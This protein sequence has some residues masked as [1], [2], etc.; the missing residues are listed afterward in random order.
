MIKG[1][2]KTC[3]VGKSISVILIMV[4]VFGMP[5]KSQTPQ[6]AFLWQKDDSF[7]KSGITVIPDSI[8]AEKNATIVNIL[9]GQISGVKASSAD[10]APGAAFDILIRGINSVRG[11]N[12]PLFIV[13]GIML[14]S[15]NMDVIN[16]WRVLD[17][18]D[19]Q[20]GQ[21]LLWGLNSDNIAQIDV[22]KD[23]SATALYGSK[24]AN[25]VV[26]IK[27]KNGN[28]KNMELKWISNIG[29]SSLPKR[30]DLLSADQYTTYRNKLSSPFNSTGLQSADWQNEAFRNAISNNHNLS[31]SGTVRSTSYNLSLFYGDEQG[32]VKG[33]FAKNFGFKVNL[34]Q[35]I[36]DKLL[37]GTRILFSNSQV[38]MTQSN[39]YL[40][41]GGLINQ[42]SAA[43][44]EGLSENAGSWLNGYYDGANS[45]RMLPNMY[46][47]MQFSRS[48]S[49]IMNGGADYVKKTRLRW[50]GTEIDRGIV[51]NARA[52][53]SDLSALQYN[54][55]ATLTFNRFINN[56]HQFHFDLTGGYFGNENIA[57]STQSSDFFSYTLRAKG[58]NLGA[59]MMG[60]IYTK[61]IS[62]TAFATVNALY[63]Y[64][65]IYQIK[66][67]LRSDYL[68]DYD[69][70][71]SY[72]PF[73]QA[74]WNVAKETFMKN[75]NLSNLS[76][77]AGYGIS[78]T[79]SVDM[80]S[81]AGKY[82]LGQGTLWVPFEKSLNYRTR[83]QTQKK[84]LNVG[85]ETSLINNRLS[86][87]VNYYRGVVN[88]ALSAYNF[89]EPDK[90]VNADNTVTYIDPLKHF[91]QNSMILDKQGAEATI[92]MSVI[93][94]KNAEWNVS[95]NI[96]VDRSVVVESASTST[97]GM[98]GADGFEGAS[99]GVL[100]GNA[101]N[102]T[103]FI[104]GRAPGVF[105]GY[106]TQGI[107]GPDHV[108]LTPPLKGQRLEVGDIKYID[109][110]L[111]GQVD[112][113]DK[114]VIGNPN[115]DFVFG[116]NTSF[117][118]KQWSATAGLDGTIGNDVLN[119]NLLNTENVSGLN[120]ISSLAYNNAWESGT[121]ENKY[122]KIGSSSLNDITNRIVEDGSFV[123]LSSLSIGYDFTLKSKKTLSGLRIN[124][125]AS[126]LFV[127]SNY[128]GYDPEV[129]SFSGNWSI[130]GVDSGAYP[131]ARSISLGL[132]AKF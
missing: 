30:L 69:E 17:G 35:R 12:Q 124:M 115:P 113:N 107:I 71:P 82:T 1:I 5:V 18:L 85:L 120:N 125:V 55:D 57:T 47:K 20:S 3:I 63:N 105:Y 21:N 89:S 122:P 109:T 4:A 39:S 9:K 64:K 106:L 126:N 100:A 10:G 46:L 128:S 8:L 42:L 84:E 7:S 53:L 99:L 95:A 114:V 75:L 73:V 117:R 130:R 14:N 108:T 123:R 38:S 76:L 97:L 62:S 90:I 44:Y 70:N 50:L 6:K 2:V 78:G 56:Y 23:A 88:D 41:A 94:T 13:D 110:N 26:I 33:T 87:D 43:P 36:N 59:K 15:A 27:T 129:N 77:K 54:V 111:D 83:L 31:L 49:L 16:S 28:K 22:L 68:L 58:I 65:D 52:G 72:F 37:F 116:F 93:K 25:G 81:D 104:D 118:Y 132:V 79:N 11:D 103:A 74:K 98:T 61:N 45:W 119:L 131:S 60:P 127:I 19:Y 86:I 48:W 96:A 112:E 29:V 24:G 92:S 34:D 67:G 91:W 51:S 66:G 102:A 40:G 32:I 80:Y 121:V 101:V